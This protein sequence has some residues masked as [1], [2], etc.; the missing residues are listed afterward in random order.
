[1]NGRGKGIYTHLKN[2]ESNVVAR[3]KVRSAIDPMGNC[4]CDWSPKLQARINTQCTD[5]ESPEAHVEGHTCAR[6]RGAQCCDGHNSLEEPPHAESI[7]SQCK[8]R[9]PTTRD[10]KFKFKHTPPI[11]Q[12]RH[13]RYIIPKFSPATPYVRGGNPQTSPAPYMAGPTSL[14][15][16][17]PS[18]SEY[19]SLMRGNN[20]AERRP[21]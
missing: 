20:V 5:G 11:K 14:R 16:L 7:R 6:L 10:R 4:V 1:M 8:T 3:E 17:S 13:Q 18:R 21:S 2:K 12:A 19:L 9:S 15:S